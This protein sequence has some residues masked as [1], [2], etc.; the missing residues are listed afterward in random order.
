MEARARGG[1]HDPMTTRACLFISKKRTME[2]REEPLADPSDDEI[3]VAC[4]ANGICMWEVSLFLDLEPEKFPLPWRA[5]HEGVGIVT[6]VGR[7]V[8]GIREGER[9]VCREWA[10]ASNMKAGGAVRYR[11]HHDDPAT[12][13]AEPVMC[14]ATALNAYEIA[15]GDRVLLLGAGYMGLLNVQGLARCPIAELVVTDVKKE[16]LE[17]ARRFGATRTI[18]TSTDEGRREQDDLSREPF[19]L[20]IDAAGVDATIQAAPRLTRTG[21]RIA[22]FAWHHARRS[23]DL[24]LWHFGGFRVLNAAPL[25]GTDSAIDTFERAVRLIDAGLFDQR[26]LITHRHPFT[27]AQEALDLAAERPAG[28]IKGVLTFAA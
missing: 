5:G 20:T 9:V 2:I 10:T 17:L 23:I 7:S 21:G 12:A 6:K 14:V 8:S 19:D 1:H 4:L 15:A 25:I 24:G 22:I 27:Q 18:D 16:N 28:Y 11:R 13:I 3:Q 26:A